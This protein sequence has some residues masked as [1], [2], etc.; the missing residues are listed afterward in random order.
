MP[1]AS[2][3]QRRRKQRKSLTFPRAS[4]VPALPLV[5]TCKCCG[6]PYEAAPTRL[7]YAGILCDECYTKCSIGRVCKKGI[8][9]EEFEKYRQRLLVEIKKQKRAKRG[10]LGRGPS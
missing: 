1:Y 7:G 8:S 4:D 2:P 6:D 5:K 3:W 9:D 10:T